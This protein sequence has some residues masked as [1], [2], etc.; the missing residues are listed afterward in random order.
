MR[1]HVNIQDDHPHHRLK[2]FALDSGSIQLVPH[3]GDQITDGQT[4]RTVKERV[5]QYGP[6]EITITLNCTY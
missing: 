1:I 2:S 4:I 5:F 6:D 3:V